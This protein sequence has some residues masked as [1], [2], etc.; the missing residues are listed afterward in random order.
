MRISLFGLGYVGVVTLVCL[1]E[2]GH[3]VWGVD[4][5]ERKL[6]MLR[7]GDPPVD[8]PGVRKRLNS[9][10][11]SKRIHLTQNAGTAVKNTE[12]GLISVG[13]PP[14]E[15]GNLDNSSVL[16]VIESILGVKSS[17]RRDYTIAIR[18]TLT[19]GSID[20]E[21]LPLI[22]NTNSF[23][24]NVVFNPEFL[25]E[26]SAISD[27][28]DPPFIV[29]GSQVETPVQ[30]IESV[31]RG[32]E[33]PL[34]QMGFKEAEM[35]KFVCNAFHALKV[36]FANEIGSIA[37]SI[38]ASPGEVMSTFVRDEKLNISSKYLK[39]GFAFGG[40][41]LP[42][43]VQSIVNVAHNNSLNLSLLTSILTSNESHIERAADNILKR[44][45]ESVAISGLSFKSDT[46]DLR[47]SPALKLAKRLIESGEVKLHLYSYGIDVDEIYGKNI[48]YLKETVPDY[49]RRIIDL[50]D[51]DEVD[52]CV[53]TR[54]IP[55]VEE[56]AKSIG[57]QTINLNDL[58]ALY[59]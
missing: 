6:E 2:Q 27:F 58:Q 1:A 5:D 35:L 47:N 10:A 7:G 55:E 50:D 51:M 59:A 36:S 49:R 24:G 54:S 8:E 9:P 26:G 20:Q 14:T 28:Y 57:V 56:H 31:Y 4:I 40:S 16:N 11:I 13:T 48:S 18:S 17:H 44:D 25:R 42:K 19:P 22:N 41:C 30:Q 34:I 23:D 37:S 29:V 38:G 3:D 45:V 53:M 43:D 15:N 46:D 39:P 32:V 12:L 21:V 52:L 33:A